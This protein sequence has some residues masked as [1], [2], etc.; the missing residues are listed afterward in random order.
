MSVERPKKTK[1]HALVLA[2][3]A[4]KRFGAAKQL[5]MIGGE[6][7]LARTVS[8]VNAA[9]FDTVSVVLSSAVAERFAMPSSLIDIV[10]NPA[11][12]RGLL[13]SIKLGCQSLPPDGAL[14]DGVAFIL[15]D[16]PLLTSVDLAR[17]IIA[18][19]NKNGTK[20]VVPMFGGRRGN[21]V[22][23]PR[24]Y[25]DEIIAAPDADHGAAFMLKRHADHVHFVEMATEGV[26]LDMDTQA[27]YKSLTARLGAPAEA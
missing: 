7:M 2:A 6:Q 8:Q 21:P 27:D 15:A 18:Y 12:E 13:S 20:I 19:A 17:L 14:R 24:H 16:Q 9:G 25:M 1:I 10:I 23:M 3:G 4:S 5:A 26:I 22:I 11:P